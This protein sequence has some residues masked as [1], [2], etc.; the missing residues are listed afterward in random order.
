MTSREEIEVLIRAR[1]PI[2]YVISFEE[3]RVFD[4]L[5]NIAH[6]L[7][8]PLRSWSVTHG[9]RHASEQDQI[10]PPKTSKLSADLDILAQIHGTQEST[11]FLLRDYHVY[12]N[13]TRVTRLLRELAPRLRARKQT[14]IICAPTLRLPVELEKEV[15]VLEFALPEKDEIDAVI[16][17][18]LEGVSDNTS[19]N[20]SLTQEQREEIIHACMGLTLDEVEAVLARSIVEKKSLDVSII[21]EQKKQIVKKSGLLQYYSASES[22]NNVG[23]ME[24]IK[25]WL[26]KRTGSF[27]E[28]AREYGLPAPKGVLLLGVQGCGKSLIAKSIANLWNLPMLRLDVGR[29]F[30]SLVGQ[31]EENIRRAIAVAESVAPCI[32]WADELEKGFAGVQGSSVSDSGTT[33]RVF[34]TFLTW[35]QEKT[36][37]V[38]FVATANDVSQLPPELLR[39]GRFDEIFFIDLPDM[40]E[41]E[42][43]FRIHIAKRKRKP[44]DFDIKQLAKESKGF[45]GAEIEQIV[46]SAM[47]ASFHEERELEQKDLIN[48]IKNTIPLS[49]MMRE[50]IQALREWA[51]LRARPAGRNDEPLDL[52]SVIQT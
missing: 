51:K 34:A 36:S 28:K 52:N 44:Q 50:D 1:Y 21:L 14:I 12:L 27:S 46:V 49:V 6:T 18:A 7:K 35:M 32:L 8:K 2:L 43:I 24:H 38:F 31:S 33:A 23:G 37:S 48:E 22:M 45:S 20:K 5:E 13:D 42:E 9:L 16:D 41:R 17:S 29:I 19:I 47:F 15:T 39:K 40:D 3:N 26:S 30:G 25:E 11:I 10:E 4:V